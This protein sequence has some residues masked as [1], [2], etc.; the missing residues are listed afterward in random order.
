[1]FYSI[2]NLSSQVAREMPD[3]AAFKPNYG[4]PYSDKRA[5]LKWSQELG[6]EHSFVSLNE[7]M[8]PIVRVHSKDNPLF[9]MHGLIADYDAPLPDDVVAK[10]LAKPQSDFKPSWLVRTISGNGRLVWLFESPVTVMSEDHYKKIIRHLSKKLHLNKWLAGLDIEALSS[11]T[12]Y[13]EHGAEWVP[14]PFGSPIPNAH[15]RHWVFECGLEIS[16][17]DKKVFTYDVPMEE[18]A[19]EVH[20]RFPG[21][22]KGDFRVGAQGVRFWDPGADNP[23]GAWIREDGVVCFTGTQAFLSWEQI[24]GRDFMAKYATLAVGGI[25]EDSA[26]NGRE[27]FQRTDNGWISCS[28]DDFSQM[29][30]VKGFNG[31][32]DAKKGVSK[33]DEIEHMIKVERRIEAAFPFMFFKPGIIHW[34]HKPYLNISFTKCLQPSPPLTEGRMTLEDGET[35]F[36]FIHSLLTTM[37]SDPGSP[38]DDGQLEH[39]LA[40]LKYFYVNSLNMTPRQGQAIVLAGPAGKGK[41]LLTELIIGDL[42]GGRT[43]ATNHLVHG[44]QWTK[45]LADS[46]VMAIEDSVGLG[47][48]R[49]LNNFSNKLKK[50]VAN[51]EI[52]F[53]QKF[54]D[55]GSVP[56][57][58]RVVITCNLDS[59]S[60]RI[61]PNMDISIRDKVSLFCT[62]NHIMDFPDR[63]V[64][65]AR[66]ASE[67]PV[68]A[69]FLIDWVIPEKLV[70]TERRFGVKAYHHVELLAES[71]QQGTGTLVE[72]LQGYMEQ[73]R[74]ERKTETAWTGLSTQLQNE[75]NTFN[76]SAMREITHRSLQTQLGMM[77]KNGYGVYKSADTMTGVKTW[78]INFDL[79]PDRK[80][81]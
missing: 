37:F 57:F 42:V 43:D 77:A 63:D 16:P 10:L 26:Y 64:T 3:P 28:K 2:P 4:A 27:F 49:A 54:K 29:L 55:S 8:S 80:D 30:R 44:D 13:Y 74:R 20:R 70:S 32:S 67:L 81:L 39:F 40:W 62:S 60:L 51:P 35:R 23:T 21:R 36:P 34:R 45:D 17:G 33:I 15:V 72:V 9:R 65:K 46:A 5:F 73:Y 69:R 53:N 24:F 78:R 22:W 61:M 66:I 56:W 12:R 58:G 1:M 18:L 79:Q 14:L 71:R 7:G 41:S 68:F 52:L 25:L 19:Q 47:D 76:P 38:R 11:T 50:Y 48:A 75:L 6:T 59:E 31:K